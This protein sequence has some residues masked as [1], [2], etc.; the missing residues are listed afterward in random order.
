MV[1]AMTP[2][3]RARFEADHW[4]MRT[5]GVGHSRFSGPGDA[6]DVFLLSEYTA[7]NRAGHDFDETH[8][9]GS[10]VPFGF[11]PSWRRGIWTGG[12][13]EASYRGTFEILDNGAL[14][15]SGEI[16]GATTWWNE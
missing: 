11:A 3:E 14:M 5:I 2:D 7:R 15:A 6:Y 13:R 12:A 1:Q 10:V 4:R 16:Q 8:P 9:A